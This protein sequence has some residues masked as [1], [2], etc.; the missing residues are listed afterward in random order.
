MSYANISCPARPNSVF[1]HNFSPALLEIPA[2]Q[3]ITAKLVRNS[4]PFPIRSLV[5]S[6]GDWSESGKTSAVSV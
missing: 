2:A 1:C 3:E 4:F 6:I 5:K